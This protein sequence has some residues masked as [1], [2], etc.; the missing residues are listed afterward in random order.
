[1]GV[2]ADDKATPVTRAAWTAHL[3]QKALD[4][5]DDYPPSAQSE[6]DIQRAILAA[7]RRH[8]AVAWVDRRNSGALVDRRGYRVQL[9][10]EGTT[11]LEGMTR[12]EP[13]HGTPGR[14]FGIEIKAPGAPVR[15]AQRARIAEIRGL[16]HLAGVARSVDD[17]LRIL[18]GEEV[19]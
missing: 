1:V 15:N 13:R 6:A 9:C 2:R 10:A 16:G 8:P 18:G 4:L 7:L 14:F 11:D 3:R 12:R 5:G 19:D 17:A